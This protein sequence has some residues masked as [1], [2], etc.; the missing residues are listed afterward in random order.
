M[1]GPRPIA[2][3]LPEIA[4]KILGKK[5]LGFGVLITEWETIVGPETARRAMPI[6]VAFPP[7][8]RESGTLHLRV[9]G[10]YAVELQHT[11]PQLIERVNAFLGYRAI[12]A[13]RLVQSGSSA[14]SG[15]V[16]KRALAP[17]EVAQLAE[18]V[19][20]VENEELREAL[21]ALGQS[22]LAGRR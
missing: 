21:A 2:R 17:T 4:G 5:G 22:V 1:A 12:E 13:L 10:G 6:R 9:A 11:A 15:A 8:R 16:A 14:K 19:G 3:M 20:T 18:Q 7:G